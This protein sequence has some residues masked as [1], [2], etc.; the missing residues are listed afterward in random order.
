MEGQLRLV[1]QSYDRWNYST[2]KC[3]DTIGL[4][5]K[6]VENEHS[7]NFEDLVIYQYMPVIRRSWRRAFRYKIG[8]SI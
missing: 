1:C 2:V 8:K 5:R 4:K 7:F 3:K 6:Q